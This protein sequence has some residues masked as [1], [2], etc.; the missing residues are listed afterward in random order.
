M[1]S[2]QVRFG[3]PIAGIAF[4]ELGD[5]STQLVHTPAPAVDVAIQ[6]GHP[7]LEARQLSLT[8]GSRPVDQRQGLRV[9]GQLSLETLQVFEGLSL[10]G[11]GR[12][13]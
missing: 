2:A 5:S 6:R 12:I 8:F 9:A 10:R 13:E 1:A 3:S 4:F 7:L 11:A